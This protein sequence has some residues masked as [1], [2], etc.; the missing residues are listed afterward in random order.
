MAPARFAW[1]LPPALVVAGL[2]VAGIALGQPGSAFA[3]PAGAAVT[4]V[5]QLTAVQ[6]AGPCNDFGAVVTVSVTSGLASTAYTATAGGF[7]SPGTFTT[8]ST[9]AGAGQVGNVLPP[10]GWTGTATITV[11][12]AGRT[13]TVTAAIACS[14]PKGQ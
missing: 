7:S 4:P 6:A 10:S 2:V 11:T 14:P 5:G 3:A 1:K 12:A 8:G 13:G 9:G